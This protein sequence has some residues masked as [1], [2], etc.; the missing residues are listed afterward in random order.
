ML[1]PD[2]KRDV[3]DLVST[4]KLSH[5]IK[6]VPYYW[7]RDPFEQGK[8][9]RQSRSGSEVRAKIAYLKNKGCDFLAHCIESVGPQNGP[10][11]TNAIPGLSWHNY[12][13][14]V[15]CYWS[16]NGKAVWSHT[17]D[18][19]RNGYRIYARV[20]EEKGLVSL[21]QRYG[22]DWVHVQKSEYSSPLKILTLNQI[23]Q[24]MRELYEY[25]E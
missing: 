14:A 15:D 19:D 16:K 24:K 21:G 5:G 18:G 1:D 6:M 23:D 13:Q 4:L 22:W 12:G 2:F 7:V 8:L 17:E 3:L 9:W 25:S 20:A 11:V 10:S